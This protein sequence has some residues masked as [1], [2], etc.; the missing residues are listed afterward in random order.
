MS[1]VCSDKKVS[2]KAD[3]CKFVRAEFVVFM[4]E[5]PIKLKRT[6]DETDK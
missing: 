3:T 6:A 2:S 5:F 1:I 4:T